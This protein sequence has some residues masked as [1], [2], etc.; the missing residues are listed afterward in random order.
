M[1]T[2]WRTRGQR[3]DCSEKSFRRLT[4]SIPLPGFRILVTSSMKSVSRF[5]G[6]PRPAKRTWTIS[7]ELSANGSGSSLERNVSLNSR[8]LAFTNK[9]CTHKSP[10]CHVIFFA[11]NAQS[12]APSS[13]ISPSICPFLF[14]KI[15]C[16]AANG[17]RSV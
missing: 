1:S 16:T 13:L 11:A 3:G 15:C 12:I 10:I 2:I 17:L 7:K 14:R 9:T 6:M 5:S 8:F 4:S